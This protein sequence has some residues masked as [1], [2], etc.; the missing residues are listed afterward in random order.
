MFFYLYEIKNNING[1]IYIGVHTTRDLN[2]GYMGSGVYLNRAYKKH[3]M[4]NFT[5]TILEWF[6]N[7]QQMYQRE[8]EII[9]EEFLSRTDVYNLRCGGHG[10]FDYINKNKLYFDSLSRQKEFS[11]KGVEKQKWLRENDR[12]WTESVNQIARQTLI[13]AREK[14]KEK[15]PN[16]TWYGKTHSESTKKKMSDSQQ[17]KQLGEKNSQFGTMW[18]SN[19]KENKKIKKS[20]VIPEGWYPGRTM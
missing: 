12:E 8:K 11:V 3:G 10:G 9:T 7:S 13:K 5:K 1:K 14:V 18:V 17:G 16:G 4:E 2:D 15:Y 6:E 20:D 19:G